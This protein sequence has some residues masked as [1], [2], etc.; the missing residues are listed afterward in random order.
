MKGRKGNKTDAAGNVIIP[1]I[2]TPTDESCITFPLGIG[3]GYTKTCERP[4]VKL[5]QT[6]LNMQYPNVQT[7]VDGK[8]GEDTEALLYMFIFKYTVD[9]TLYDQI[10][11]DLSTITTITY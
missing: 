9:K 5:I 1:P 8:F 7:W 4:A 10:K 3:S 6:W 11:S 2:T